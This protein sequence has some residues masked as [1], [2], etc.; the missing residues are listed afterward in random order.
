VV[1][2]ER[3]KEFRSLALRRAEIKVFGREVL[4]RRSELKS[5]RNK[6]RRGENYIRGNLI[7]LDIS[8]TKYNLGHQIDGVEMGER[9]AR[10]KI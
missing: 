3:A 7:I 8:V 2:E 1:L 9:V 5:E 4:S 10:M 6:R